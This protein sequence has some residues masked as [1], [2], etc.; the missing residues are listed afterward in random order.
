[1]VILEVGLGG[2]L[3]AVNIIDADVALIT[4]IGLDHQ[5]W[6]G[7]NLESIGFE[8]AGIMRAGRPVVFASANPPDSVVAHADNIGAVQYTL[9]QA[10]QY[11]MSHSGWRWQSA[12]RTRET[13]PIPSLRGEIGRAHV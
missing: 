2:R 1:M 4:N 8:K 13:L 9:E 10:Y 12:N 6:L 7:D 5:A 11:K 3:D